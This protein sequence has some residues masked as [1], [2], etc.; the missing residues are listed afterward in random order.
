MPDFIF[1]RTP[2]PLTSEVPVFCYHVIDEPTF[3]ADLAFL[4]DN[5]YTTLTADQLLNHLTQNTPGPKRDVATAPPRSVVLSFDDGQRSLY[6]VAFPLLEE[7]NHKAV[8]FICP[9]LHREPDEN[10]NAGGQATH[11][12]LCDWQQIRRM[13]DSGRVDFQP[14]T[15]S[16]RYVPDWPKPL[17]LAGVDGNIANERRPD[18]VPLNEDLKQAKAALD[19]ALSKNTQHLAFPQYYGTPLA[20]QTAKQLGYRGFWWGVLPHQPINSPSTFPDMIVR[21]SG[22]FVR[23]LPGNGRITLRQVI[24]KR[25]G[26]PK[27]PV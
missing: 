21:T 25:Y 17:P 24:A 12:G 9:A 20:I 2:A 6:D 10:N 4:S 19:Q 1:K 3:R 27:G 13:H 22:E 18:P 5:G 11:G 15:N 23:R 7:Y 8:A 26:R 14:H 16:H